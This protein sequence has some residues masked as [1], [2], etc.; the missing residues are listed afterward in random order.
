MII[1]HENG[2]LGNQLFQYCAL[3]NFQKKD[4]LFLFGMKSL[5][6]IFDGLEIEQGKW[7]EWDC[8]G[9]VFRIGKFILTILAKKLHLIGLI[10]EHKTTS[11]SCI[12]TDSGLLKNIY[13]CEK[14]SFFQSEELVVDSVTGTL[15]LK[16][17]L[18]DQAEH[19]F[20][21]FPPD[22]SETFFVHVRRG[23]YINWPSKSS[24]AVL[25]FRW[26]QEQMDLIRSKFAKPFFVVV[27]DDGPYADEMFTMYPD[28]FVSHENEE[29]D[30]VLMTLCAGGGI[31]SASSFAWW[32]AYFARR[33]SERAVFVAPLYWAG[34]RKGSWEPESIKTSWLNYAEVS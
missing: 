14:D 21:G 4:A 1:I 11:G 27:S 30:F 8:E 26:Y 34:H 13:Y 22:R 32:A 31:L 23:D 7:L 25:P 2:R 9:K 29:I 6:S 20:M 15:H 12:V 10:R 33:N 3:R 5:K 17:N 16:R 24:P 19:I 18:L 28:V